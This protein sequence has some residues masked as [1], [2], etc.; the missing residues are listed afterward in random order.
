MALPGVDGVSAVR[1][2]V[3]G[4]GKGPVVL[5]DVYCYKVLV[6]VEGAHDGDGE[7]GRASSILVE[8]GGGAQPHGGDLGT[9]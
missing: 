7:G 9:F 5:R 1:V 2:A 6:E 4:V 3:E 8:S